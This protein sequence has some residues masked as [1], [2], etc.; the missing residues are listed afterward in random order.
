MDVV[1]ERL[2]KALAIVGGVLVVA[3]TLVTTYSILGRWIFNSPLLG[4]TEVVEYGMAVVVACFLP[5]CQWR[6]ENIIVDFFTANA[7]ERTRARLDRIGALMIA[8]MLGLI[9]WRTAVGAFDQKRSGSVTMLMQ[10][11]EWVAYLLMSIPIAVTALMALHTALTGRNGVRQGTPTHN[12]VPD[13]IHPL[14]R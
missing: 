5:I 14:E 11:P 4:D 10:W 6:G 9:A 8:L 3:I 13:G 2:A 12:P 1:F 7:T